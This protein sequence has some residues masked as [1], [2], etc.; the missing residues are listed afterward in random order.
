MYRGRYIV[1]YCL[2]GIPV[3]K[4]GV[5]VKSNFANRNGSKIH[6][7]GCFYQCVNVKCMSEC[8][9]PTSS[10][11][12]KQQVF[13]EK[14]NVQNHIYR[15]GRVSPDMLSFIPLEIQSNSVDYA[16]T[17]TFGSPANSNAM[18]LSVLPYTLVVLHSPQQT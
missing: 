14:K 2:L 18:E 4:M 5:L 12:S 7:K 13:T 1:A 6:I 16:F 17:S 8:P 10:P 11:W 9:G 15:R 3:S